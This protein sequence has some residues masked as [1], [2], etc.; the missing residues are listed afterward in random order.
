MEA[1]ELGL[2]LQPHGSSPS[3]W[4]SAVPRRTTGSCESGC[5][6]D[7]AGS[8]KFIIGKQ[9]TPRPLVLPP[10]GPW[11]ITYGVV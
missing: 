1:S 6:K 8:A 11:A 4:A 2:G 3:R 7:Q 9:S 10:P 5:R